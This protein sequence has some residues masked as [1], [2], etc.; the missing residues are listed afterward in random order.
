MTITPTTPGL[1]RLRA[2]EVAAVQRLLECGFGAASMPQHS[3]RPSV[4]A[5]LANQYLLA[6]LDRGEYHRFYAWPDGEPVGL[7][8]SGTNGTIVP[9]G[10]PTAGRPLAE[11][12]EREPWRVLVGE[13]R[14]GASMLEAYPR[15]FFRRPPTAREQRFMLARQVPPG[16]AD[17]EGF[18]LATPD[19]L[20]R[21]TDFACRLHVEDLMGP[22]ISRT[23]RGA[24]RDRM[25]ESV[26]QGQ[27]YVVE[28][29]G[30]VVA[31][32][33][34]SLRS[35]RR[36]AQIAG[37]FVDRAWRCRGIAG[38]AVAALTALQL[39]EGLPGVTLHVRAGNAPAIAAYRR[40]GYRDAGAW[41]LA[42]R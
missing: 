34:L 10:D 32:V 13:A 37:V 25:L 36:G 5:V 7:L 35:R 21:L 8:Y 33:D 9:A 39:A 14:I 40:A 28:R 26:V 6:A 41:L 2:G 29:R 30:R 1:R 42:L 18:R 22:P 15:G 24:V 19:D 17:M 31:K 23:G 20:E 3:G 11:A 38:A 16:M 27:A 12:A 4:E